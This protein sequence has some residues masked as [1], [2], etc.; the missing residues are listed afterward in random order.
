MSQDSAVNKRSVC[1][2]ATEAPAAL[3]LRPG[4]QR[5]RERSKGDRQTDNRV[6]S[7]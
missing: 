1:G 6:V 4:T 5:S 2:R 3:R 7:F